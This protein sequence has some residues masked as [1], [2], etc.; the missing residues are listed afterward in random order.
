MKKSYD[1]IAVASQVS[2]AEK[3]YEKICLRVENS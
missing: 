3:C 2:A 1:K